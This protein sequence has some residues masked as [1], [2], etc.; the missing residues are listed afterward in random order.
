M[1]ESE[2]GPRWEITALD[3]TRQGR[4]NL[5][6]GADTRAKPGAPDRSGGARQAQ[7]LIAAAG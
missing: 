5:Q 4:L 7:E 2:L 3:R 6:P 1:A